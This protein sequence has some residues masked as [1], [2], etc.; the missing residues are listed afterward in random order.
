MAE[1]ISCSHCGRK[2]DPGTP[3]MRRFVR[4]VAM[5]GKAHIVQEIACTSQCREALL[6]SSSD[7]K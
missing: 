6:S 2:L 1:T 7:S 5:D 3:V 4:K